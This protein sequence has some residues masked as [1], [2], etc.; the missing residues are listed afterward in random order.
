MLEP[1]K[2]NRA[3]FNSLPAGHGEAV[4]VLSWVLLVTVFCL[5]LSVLRLVVFLPARVLRYVS[6]P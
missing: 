5:V 4:I 1:N 2:N 6:T 3:A